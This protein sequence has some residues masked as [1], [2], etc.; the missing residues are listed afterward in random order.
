MGRT[1][2]N[3][4]PAASLPKNGT[5]QNPSDSFGITTANVSYG[6]LLRF[7]ALTAAAGSRRRPIGRSALL[8]TK[9]RSASPRTREQICRDQ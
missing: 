9:H 5:S 7:P 6:R 4:R 8:R 1:D 3:A 2:M